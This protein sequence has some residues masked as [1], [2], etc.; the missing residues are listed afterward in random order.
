[1][2][3][4]KYTRELFVRLFL[5]SDSTTFADLVFF[6]LDQIFV[7]SRPCYGSVFIASP[8]NVIVSRFSCRLSVKE[9][10]AVEREIGLF[11]NAQGNAELSK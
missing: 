5:R 1:M 7:V 3:S 10:E 2:S 9:Q 4:A 8:A 11:Q 6:F